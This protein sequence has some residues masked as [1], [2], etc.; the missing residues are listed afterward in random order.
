MKVLF[1]T[2]VLVPA[3]VLWVFVGAIEMRSLYIELKSSAIASAMRS[4]I[5]NS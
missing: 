4:I 3:L 2:S 5:T 1:D